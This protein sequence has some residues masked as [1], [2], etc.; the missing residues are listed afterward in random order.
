LEKDA[1]KD[2]SED[3]TTETTESEKETPESSEEPKP[4]KPAEVKPEAEKPVESEEDEENISKVIKFDGSVEDAPPEKPEE[5]TQLDEKPKNEEASETD[6]PPDAQPVVEEEKPAT[7][8]DLEQRRNILQNL[9]DFDF[10]IK[11]NQEDISQAMSK[12]DSLGKDLD[13]LVSLYEIVSEQ[14]N[15]FVGLSKVTKKRI[16]AL[17]HYTQELEEVKTRMG[18]LESILE[19]NKLMLGG[20]QKHAQK[21]QT[22]GQP[23]SSLENREEE[24]SN[25]DINKILEKSFDALLSDQKV[26]SIID[27]FVESFKK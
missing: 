17:E 19:K 14:M 11:K 21:R 24:L 23:P 18:D 27:E 26:D 12:L 4:D 10:Q 20:M 2:S 5:K 13:D 7:R 22:T 9:K 3:E 16:D 25:K 8:E 15:P 6:K 1:P